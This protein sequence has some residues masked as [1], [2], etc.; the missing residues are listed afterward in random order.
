VGTRAGLAR[1]AWDRFQGIRVAGDYEIHGSSTIASDARGW[2]YVGTTAGLLTGRPAAARSELEWRF[3]WLAAHTGPIN[4]LHL[5]PG[6]QAL[7]LG[8]DDQ[9][10]R[11]SDGSLTAFGPAAGVPKT[12]WEA[13]LTAPNGDLWVRG[14]GQLL[15]RSKGQPSSCRLARTCPRPATATA[16]KWIPRA[17]YWWPPIWAWRS[18]PPAAGSVWIPA[19][20]CLPTRSRARSRTARARSGS[21]WTAPVGALAGVSPMGELGRSEGLSNNDVWSIE[22]DRA[23]ALWVGTDRGLNYRARSGGLWRLWAG[24]PRDRLK[25]DPRSPSR[26]GW[27]PVG[28]ERSGRRGQP[29][30]GFQS[31]AALR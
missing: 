10:Y 25:P 11:L 28:G 6:G 1:R 22:R 18:T 12:R 16:C 3:E 13:I 24:Q 19:A 4:T 31:R 17:A 2:I 26:P 14:A 5:E 8:C 21:G 20:A 30:S 9:L 15:L 29:G 23:G 7:W 27:N